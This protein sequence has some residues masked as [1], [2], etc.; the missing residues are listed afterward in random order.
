MDSKSVT[1]QDLYLAGILHLIEYENIDK[2]TVSGDIKMIGGFVAKNKLKAL[3]LGLCGEYF[4][5]ALYLK[6]GHK[7]NKFTY[8]NLKKNLI[9]IFPKNVDKAKKR[10]DKLQEWR[11]GLVHA[12][13]VKSVITDSEISSTLSFLEYL[14][15]CINPELQLSLS[16]YIEVQMDY[17]KTNGG[18]RIFEIKVRDNLTD[19]EYEL[20]DDKFDC[21][22]YFSNFYVLDEDKMWEKRVTQYMTALLRNLHYSFLEIHSHIDVSD[23]FVVLE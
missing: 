4:L 10:V 16:I 14:E 1:L 11:N 7:F 2:D 17:K 8:Q 13:D 21:E 6:N 20:P 12:F 19:R 22:R 23:E 18:L 15:T 3:K 9:K 5:K